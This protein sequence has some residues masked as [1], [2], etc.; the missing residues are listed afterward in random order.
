MPQN[1]SPHPVL[2]YKSQQSGQQSHRLRLFGKLVSLPVSSLLSGFILRGQVIKVGHK[3]LLQA[4]Q[5]PYF[6]LFPQGQAL[7]PLE[8]APNR[9]QHGGMVHPQQR[10]NLSQGEPFSI[11][12]IQIGLLAE[13]EP[14]QH[15]LQYRRIF[16]I[17]HHGFPLLTAQ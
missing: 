17:H 13:G 3:P 16:Q 5:S 9:A 12:E 11:I 4:V 10:T 6:Y 15:H 1:H 8:P 14:V 2:P 7:H